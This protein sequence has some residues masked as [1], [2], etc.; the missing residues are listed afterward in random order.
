M[1]SMYIE[2]L[3]HMFDHAVA[4][5]NKEYLELILSKTP[6]NLKQK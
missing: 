2:I 5:S 3:N 6:K 1:P 4:I